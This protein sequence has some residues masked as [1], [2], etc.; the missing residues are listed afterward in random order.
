MKLTKV[1]TLL[2]TAIFTAVF[3]S[4]SA[5]A[6]DDIAI[7]ET[8]FPD[9]SFRSYISENYDTDKNGALSAEEIENAEELFIEDSV[10]DEDDKVTTP[11]LDLTGIN[12]LKNLKT[13]NICSRNVIN[14]DIS[15]IEAL[16]YI[17]FSAG[18][19]SGLV[20][21]DMSSLEGCDIYNSDLTEISLIDCPNLVQCYFD[22]NPD[23]TKI[24]VKNAENLRM[25]GC[26]N[27]ALESLKVENC[28]GLISVDCSNNKL[29]KLD[30]TD[31]PLLSTLNC[32]DNMI[33]EL[34]I[35]QF[36]NIIEGLKNF[37]GMP[38]DEAPLTVDSSTKVIGYDATENNSSES[39]QSTHESTVSSET[40]E[41]EKEKDSN[42][43][44]LVAALAAIVIAGIAAV[45]IILMVKGG[46]EK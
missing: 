14:A 2:G 26:R 40:Q 42:L 22:D 37:D 41:K 11:Q 29:T 35:S 9:E 34:D 12:Y 27:D 20:L 15:G 7:D 4:F 36:N 19:V 39:T 13:I 46:K 1:F 25:L 17:G 24:E 43:T 45:V 31:C 38:G 8:N 3:M 33:A 10:Y 21:G 44:M 18:N 28:A 30:I 5:Y 6:A 32:R 16:N 23:L